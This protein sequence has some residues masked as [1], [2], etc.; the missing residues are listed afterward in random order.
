MATPS[1][2]DFDVRA[3]QSY[4]VAART[5][6]RAMLR[7]GCGAA[8]R[9]FA[10]HAWHWGIACDHAALRKPRGWSRG[11]LGPVSAGLPCFHRAV[12]VNYVVPCALP[13][14]LTHRLVLAR[15]G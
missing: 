10:C 3:T 2:E 15:R 6:A 5:T 13:P 8:Q 12:I 1:L 9:T 14:P 11:A 7:G 4:A